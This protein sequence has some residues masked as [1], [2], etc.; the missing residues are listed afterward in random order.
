MYRFR[1]SSKRLTILLLSYHLD[2]I[3]HLAMSSPFPFLALPIGPHSDSSSS[4]SSSSSLFAGDSQSS[5]STDIPHSPMDKEPKV[6][7]MSLTAACTTRRVSLKLYKINENEPAAYLGNESSPKTPIQSAKSGI[8]HLS[9]RS[10]IQLQEEDVGY[11][12]DSE[13]GGSSGSPHPKRFS[14]FRMSQS[15]LLRNGT[16]P[17]L[18]RVEESLGGGKP[19]LPRIRP[20]RPSMINIGATC[21]QSIQLKVD[22]KL[23]GLGLG[24]PSNHPLQTLRGL[25]APTLMSPTIVHKPVANL[26]PCRPFS[27]L[28]PRTRQMQDP[29]LRPTVVPGSPSPI[30][31][32]PSRISYFQKRNDP[33]PLQGSRFAF[34]SPRE[35]ILEPLRPK[36]TVFPCMPSSMELYSSFAFDTV[37]PCTPFTSP[38]VHASGA[39]VMG[40]V[41]MG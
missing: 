27:P 11:G 29:R 12:S 30:D 17:I 37:Y 28:S 13:D 32:L 6:T 8:F 3:S 41:T 4:G 26:L 15:A 2:F 7:G 14:D 9:P 36:S 22:T 16:P 34:S 23:I 39:R 25:T 20:N 35:T 18:P 40:N 33:S 24:L 21:P 38:E 19:A 10:R 1:T 31:M 5:N